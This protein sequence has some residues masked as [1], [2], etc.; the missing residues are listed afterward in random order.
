[1]SETLIDEFPADDKLWL[2]KW[3]DGFQ[4]ALHRTGSA[5][6]SVLL[7]ELPRSSLAQ[8]SAMTTEEIIGMLG[9]KSDTLNLVRVTLH[10]GTISK[11]S[12]GD[13]YQNKRLVTQLRYEEFRITLP[14]GED[15][16]LEYSLT[17]DFPLPRYWTKGIPSRIL[18]S[19]EF[20]GLTSK[21]Q[22]ESQRFFQSRCVLIERRIADKHTMF[23]IPRTTIFKSFYALNSPLANA[24]CDGPWKDQ[25]EVAICINDIKSGQKTRM[26]EGQWDIVL[27]LN[28]PDPC[29]PLLAVLYFDDYGRESAN[30][31]YSR[32][33]QERRA[34]ESSVWFA[35][36]RIPYQAK[37]EPLS[38]TFRCLRIKAA[39]YLD[40]GTK[41]LVTSITKSN[42]PSHYPTIVLGRTNNNRDGDTVEFTDEP[43]PFAQETTD[44]VGLEDTVIS[45][46]LDAQEQS[47]TNHFQG[48][49]WQWENAPTTLEMKKEY[50]KRYGGK[51][52]TVDNESNMTSTGHPTYE[53]G[54][55]PKSDINQEIRLPNLHFSHVYDVFLQLSKDGLLSDCSAFGP[56]LSRLRQ[57]RNDLSVWSFVEP[58]ETIYRART[59]PS[60]RILEKGKHRVSNTYRSALI[61]N[62]SYCGIMFYWIEIEHRPTETGFKSVVMWNII[63]DAY[64]CL[65]KAVEI[66]AQRKGSNI[67]AAFYN[68]F[69]RHTVRFATRRHGYNAEKTAM[70][71]SSVK[72]FLQ[73]LS[74]ANFLQPL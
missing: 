29:A 2:I 19:S 50:S 68:A 4:Q 39:G 3:I 40:K 72:R 23:V 9:Q 1:M 62:F 21:I 27:Q 42:W 74:S 14:P 6:I 71:P 41:L 63:E 31:I 33:L 64:T 26:Y 22:G 66:I 58:P 65:E 59:R 47:H 73:E 18:N 12:I 30:L 15:D 55:Y 7:Q 51:R 35:N 37:Q 52:V 60:W 16:S 17:D 28:M 48:I 20:S 44:Q 25:L 61:V 46:A 56:R 36:A 24:F 5:G 43:K 57:W 8:I 53:Q 45:A 10:V 67:E 69:D 32:S 49:D 38:L 11:F 70:T 13:I 34:S 54:N